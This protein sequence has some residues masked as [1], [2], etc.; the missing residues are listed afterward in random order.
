MD[1]ELSDISKYLKLFHRVLTEIK[2]HVL[3][4][5][6]SLG[7][8]LVYIVVDTVVVVVWY[9][10][11]SLLY[12]GGAQEEWRLRVRIGERIERCE[13]QEAGLLARIYS[14]TRQQSTRWALK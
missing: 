2:Q 5:L 14:E 12:L 10:L 11:D 6:F 1:C 7:H 9:V 4:L 13:S 3:K 8:M